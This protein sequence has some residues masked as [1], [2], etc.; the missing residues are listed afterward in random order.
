MVSRDIEK[1]QEEEIT[2]KTL[3]QIISDLSAEEK[4]KLYSDLTKG[5]IL[6]IEDL[7]ALND[8]YYQSDF[9]STK[10]LNHLLLKVSLNRK[11]RGE[12]IEIARSILNEEHKEDSER[13]KGLLS[14]FRGKKEHE[15]EH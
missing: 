7:L 9:I 3:T 11:G 10:I 2:K 14:R 8:N 6:V 12:S 4:I 13:K 1:L 15:G 5:E